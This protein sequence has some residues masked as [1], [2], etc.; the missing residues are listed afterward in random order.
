MFSSQRDT[1]L[2]NSDHFCQ[3]RPQ[4]PG[5]VEAR[6]ILGKR[7]AAGRRVSTNCRNT[8]SLGSTR[9]AF[10]SPGCNSG[11]GMQGNHT[12]FHFQ[13]YVIHS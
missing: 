3:H 12:E 6:P 7:S 9:T 1:H 5:G 4:A 8:D 11:T 2:E 10:H 13:Q